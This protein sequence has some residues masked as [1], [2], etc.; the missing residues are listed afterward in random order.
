MTVEIDEAIRRDPRLLRDVEAATAYLLTLP[1]Y[2]PP[3]RATRWWRPTKIDDYVVLE[4]DDREGGNPVS[5]IFFD[6]VRRD[7]SRRESAVRWAWID[8]LEHRS[9]IAHSRV[10]Q[11]MAELEAE[12]ADGW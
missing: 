10:A 11:T 3:P 6:R 1:E 9:K 7:K 5:H 2:V 8:L 4:L 12:G